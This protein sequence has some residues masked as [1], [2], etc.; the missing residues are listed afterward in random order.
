MSEIKK[1]FNSIDRE[2]L[3]SYIRLC[4][5]VQ[6]CGYP[7]AELRKAFLKLVDRSE[8]DWSEREDYIQYL[9]II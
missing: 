2:D 4:Y 1:R 9:F 8:Y 7:R 5:A 3:G 6:S